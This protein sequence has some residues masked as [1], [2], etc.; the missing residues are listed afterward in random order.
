MQLDVD[1]EPTLRFP[2]MTRIENQMDQ[3]E[4]TVLDR[5]TDRQKAM[6]KS[7][8]CNFPGRP[9]VATVLPLNYHWSTLLHMEVTLLC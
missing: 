2:G 5:Q 4:S 9:G 1:I 6:H 3:S 7:P 8:L